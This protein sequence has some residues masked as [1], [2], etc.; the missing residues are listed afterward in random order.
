MANAG[1]ALAGTGGR[2]TVDSVNLRAGKWS[3]EPQV[4]DLITTN[5]ESVGNDDHTYEEGITDGVRACPITIEMFWDK[6][7]DP[8]ADPPNLKAGETIGPVELFLAKT[9]VQPFSCEQV[10]VLSTPIVVDLDDK[11]MITIQG[12]TN[13][14]YTYPSVG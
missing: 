5:F 9:G 14:Q 4:N 12:R 10:R 3:A 11:V 8:H 7:Q 6:G 13:G 1:T 2:V